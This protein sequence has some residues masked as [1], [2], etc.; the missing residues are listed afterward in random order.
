MRAYVADYPEDPEGWYTYAE[1]LHH[2][3]EIEPRSPD[4]VIAAFDK[5]IA[6]DSTLTPAVVHPLELAMIYRDRAMFRRYL[7]VFART[8]PRA[9]VGA[10]R[11]G[12]ALIWGPPPGDSALRAALA[13]VPHIGYYSVISSYRDETATSDSILG[14]RARLIAGT[15]AA[16]PVRRYEPIDR[17]F[18]LIGFGRLREAKG[19]VDSV[20]ALDP[21]AAAGMLGWPVALGMAPLSY[22]GTRVDSLMALEEVEMS[23]PRR[24][25]YVGAIRALSHGRPDEAVTRATEGMRAP[26]PSPDSTRNNGLL[27]AAVGWAR[28][29]QGDTAQ[30]LADLRAGLSVTGGPRSGEGA[31][32][33]FQLALALAANPRTRAEG[34][35]RLRYGFSGSALALTPLT[36][37]ALG[38]TYEAAGKADSAVIAYGR[39]VRLWDKADPELQGRVVEAREALSRLT[40]EPRGGG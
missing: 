19:L 17:G 9:R 33:R 24:A 29:T 18:M 8:A 28:L 11:V 15:P 35:T 3:Q 6:A 31:Y 10:H 5:V 7:R 32:L 13:A 34:I 38:R 36:Y 1:A 21:G 40:S 23:S 27:R 37:L 22:A 26:D 4:S 12:E 30:G 25:A 16:S 39:F 14:L 20:A 2:L